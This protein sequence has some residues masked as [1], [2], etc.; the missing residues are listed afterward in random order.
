MRRGALVSP[1]PTPDD[2]IRHLREQVIYLQGRGTALLERARG[3]ETL[4]KTARLEIDSAWAAAL[5]MSDAQQALEAL[6]RIAVAVLVRRGPFI[7]TLRRAD[8]L[9]CHPGGKVAA[10]ESIEEAAAR[11]LA[12]ETGIE[13]P[14]STVEKLDLWSFER[15]SAGAFLIVW[16]LVEVVEHTEARLA[17]PDKFNA[18]CWSTKGDGWPTPLLP[19]SRTLAARTDVDPWSLMPK[20]RI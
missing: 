19:G 9:W 3:A 16:C 7:L 18:L 20:E 13:V 2:E 10:G 11:E 17:E 14:M 12:E 8:G 15:L 5:R 4:N 6:P 1:F